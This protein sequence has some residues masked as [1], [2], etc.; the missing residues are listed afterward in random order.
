MGF[1]VFKKKNN[2]WQVVREEYSPRKK[3][4][5]P[6]TEFMSLGFRK[7]MTIDE[8]RERAKQLNR[9]SKIERDR[10]RIVA[11]RISHEKLVDNAYLPAQLVQEFETWLNDN[12]R[13]G[14]AHLI[15]TF[16]HWTFVKK[17][18]VYLQLEP[19]EYAKNMVRI[20]KYFSGTN[21]AKRPY[22][23]DYTVKNI[24]LLNKWG[25]FASEHQGTYYKPVPYPSGADRESIND[26]YW[27]STEH[28][29]GESAPIT[30]KM[31]RG[32]KF[33]NENQWNWVFCT[34]WLGLRPSEM[35]KANDPKFARWTVEKGVDVLWIYQNKLRGVHRDKRWKPLP[36]LTKEQKRAGEIVKSGLFERPL[37]RTIQ[38]A[39]GNDQVTT[40]GGRKGFTDLMRAKHHPIDHISQWLGHRSLDTTWGKYKQADVVLFK[41]PG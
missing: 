30:P 21:E 7:D 40:Y 9:L 26:A 1:S 19:K 31:L 15:R 25:L 8:A 14:A 6:F 2:R 29:V 27:G 11:V 23:L 24:S 28:Y 3:T 33:P 20:Y 35:D 22:S 17:M 10:A 13:G 36:L 39:L 4:A 18:V 34:V 37:T 41:K 38:L 5:V 16:K 32:A 12:T